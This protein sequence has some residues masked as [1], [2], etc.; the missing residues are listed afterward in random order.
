MIGL[1]KPVITNAILTLCILFTVHRHTFLNINQLDL[2]EITFEAAFTSAPFPSKTSTTSLC[3]FCAAAC[4]GVKPS[5]GIQLLSKC[6]HKKEDSQ[7]RNAGQYQF[8][9]IHFHIYGNRNKP[10]IARKHNT[11]MWLLE[12]TCYSSWQKILVCKYVKWWQLHFRFSG[13]ALN[14]FLCFGMKLKCAP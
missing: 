1:M 10:L 9:A 7:G 8:L 2:L 4:K 13:D 11:S 5:C 3:P 12:E 6:K 14:N